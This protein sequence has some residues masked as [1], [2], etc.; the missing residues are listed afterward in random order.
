MQKGYSLVGF[1]VGY[2]WHSL[3][4]TGNMLCSH[5]LMLKDESGGASGSIEGQGLG[6]VSSDS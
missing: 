1:F 5:G 2:S 4:L 6:H 3:S